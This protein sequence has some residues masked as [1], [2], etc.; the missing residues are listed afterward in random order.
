MGNNQLKKQEAEE[1][2]KR[3]REAHV[4]R[5]RIEQDRIDNP[6]KCRPKASRAALRRARLWATI[7]ATTQ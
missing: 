1:F 3:R 6:E 5:V 2:N 7:A 4:E